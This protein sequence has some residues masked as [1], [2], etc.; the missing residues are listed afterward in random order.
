[1]DELMVGQ[2]VALEG[3]DVGWLDGL[4]DGFPV[5]RLLG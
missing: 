4:F 1:M 2:K 5:G 3:C